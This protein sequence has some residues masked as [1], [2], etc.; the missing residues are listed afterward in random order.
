M[1]PAMERSPTPATDRAYR[2]AEGVLFQKL[3]RDAVLLNLKTEQYYSLDGVGTRIWQ[4]LG[5]T[6]SLEATVRRMLAEYTV[7]E[8]TV[9]ADTLAL[10]DK[11]AARGLLVEETE[12]RDALVA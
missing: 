2:P 7:D 10:A 5:E 8:A 6:G 3:D 11:L 4:L 9:R 1:M 12:R